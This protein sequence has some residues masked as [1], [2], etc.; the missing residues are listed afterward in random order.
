MPIFDCVDFDAH[1]QVVL[2]SDAATGLRAIIAI[3]DTTLGPALGGC[4]MWPYPDEDAAV[5]DALRLSRGM[6]YKSALAGL[7]LGGGKS[8]ILGDPRRDKTP[9]L[10]RAMGQ[11]VE[12]L[13]GRYVVAEDVGM[14]VDDMAAVR[15]RTRHVVGL[16]PRLGGRGDPSPSTARGVLAGMRAALAHRG[17]A[18]FDGVTV[19]VQG[20]GHVGW[21]V[22]QLLHQA[23]AD[24]VVADLDQ[25]VVEKACQRFGARAGDAATIHAANADIY[26]P[27]ALG[28]TLNETTIPDLKAGIVAGSANNQLATPDDADRLSQRD[29]LYIPD[30]LLN[31]GGLIQVAGDYLGSDT[32]DV[33]RRVDAIGATVAEILDL[34]DRDGVSPAVA[35]DRLAERKVKPH[36]GALAA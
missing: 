17:V 34:A 28:A 26:A 35:A 7:P 32:A 20:L 22:C 29:I 8:V 36:R 10:M 12:R 27:C 16:P 4:R 13:A 23:G 2:A 6:T 14:S 33:D 30:Y 15:D 5:R 21:N 18:G 3:H 9:D 11:A 31:A 1:E 19:A 25:T 24:L